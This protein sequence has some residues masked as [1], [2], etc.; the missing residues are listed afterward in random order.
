MPAGHGAQLPSLSI[1]LIPFL[2]VFGRGVNEGWAG[3]HMRF[4]SLIFDD[5]MDVWRIIIMEH[6]VPPDLNQRVSLL[7]LITDFSRFS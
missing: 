4:A 3:P 5:R 7:P 6:Q 1:R 2:L